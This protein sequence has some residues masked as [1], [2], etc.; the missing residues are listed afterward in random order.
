MVRKVAI[1]LAATAFMGAILAA[2]TAD[3]RMGGMGGHFGGGM[4]GHFGGGMGMHSMGMG[5]HSWGGGMRG[6]GMHPAFVGSGVRTA[7]FVNGAHGPFFRPGDR[8]AFIFHNHRRFVAAPFF[9]GAAVG[10]GWPY[11]S[12][13][14]SD[15]CW[16][17]TWTAWGPRT[18]YTCTYY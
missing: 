15:P 8:R 5:L 16:V 10:A 11:Y 1:A 18:V 12:D 4:G 17:T 9:V 2:N 7:H 14:Y 13:Y 6:F 3:A